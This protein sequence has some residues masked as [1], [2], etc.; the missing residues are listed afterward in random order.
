RLGVVLTRPRRP[1]DSFAPTTLAGTPYTEDMT[2]LSVGTETTLS[3]PPGATVLW[4]VGRQPG[5]VLLRH[6]RGKVLVVAGPALP[7]RR[8][9]T[10]EAGEPRDDNVVFLVNVA[11]LE[12][13]DRAVLFDEYHHGL[14][15]GT[16]FWSYLA[17]RGARW[18]LLPVLVVVAAALWRGAVRLGPA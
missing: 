11:R 13:R 8:G 17:H 15:A 10:R 3:A 12:A 1:S 2:S 6:G 5:A 7:T 4:R 14:R 9:L 16:G 18:A